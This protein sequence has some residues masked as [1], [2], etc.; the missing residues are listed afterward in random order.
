MKFNVNIVLYEATKKKKSSDHVLTVHNRIAIDWKSP[1][2]CKLRLF[3]MK[4]KSPNMFSFRFGEASVVLLLCFLTWS[5]F[6]VLISSFRS[7]SSNCNSNL[8][9]FSPKCKY[10][11]WSDLGLRFFL[12]IVI[13]GLVSNQFLI[14]IFKWNSNFVFLKFFF[15][16]RAV[17]KK[18]PAAT[19]A[20]TTKKT[21]PE[22]LLKRTK[23]NKLHAKANALRRAHLRKVCYHLF[24]W[25]ITWLNRN[26]ISYFYLH[27]QNDH[28]LNEIKTIKQPNH[29]N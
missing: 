26:L 10:Q 15:S 5:S 18:A 11:F 1:S 7:S 19:P 23:L 9:K 8:F 6:F 27:F 12:W 3:E 14:K 20:T 24:F 13:L 16:I 2:H 21:V 25:S 29:H 28:Q 22:S 17:D 4:R